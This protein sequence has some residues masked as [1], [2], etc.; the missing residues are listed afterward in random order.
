MLIMTG[1]HVHE[2]YQLDVECHWQPDVFTLWCDFCQP[3]SNIIMHFSAHWL[4][5]PSIVFSASVQWHSKNDQQTYPL[6]RKR[7]NTCAS[8]SLWAY[9]TQQLFRKFQ[10]SQMLKS[11]M[12]GNSVKMIG[13]IEV[14]WPENRGVCGLVT[15][16][17]DSIRNMTMNV[18]VPIARFFFKKGFDV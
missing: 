4:D 16:E 13:F 15:F 8:C 12:K 11:K 14:A 3:S 5:K 6:R 7:F 1:R 9:K 10:A 18:K 17:W 2:I